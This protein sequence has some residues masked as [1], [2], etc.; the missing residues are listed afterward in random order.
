MNKL[1]SLVAVLAIGLSACNSNNKIS[2]QSPTLRIKAD[3]VGYPAESVKIAIIPDST[4][5]DFEVYNVKTNEVV[6]KGKTSAAQLWSYSQTKVKTADFSE[7]KTQGTYAIRCAGAVD[8]YPFSIGSGIYADLATTAAQS[9]YIQ[10]CSVEIKPEYAGVYARPAA[11]ADN[12][13]IIH[14]SAAGP[15]SKEG[16]VIS[17]SGGWYDAGD[18]GKYII[19]S[20]ITVSTMLNA[21][22]VWPDYAKN[23]KLNIPE[24][25]NQLP[26][27]IDEILV[28]LRW[29]LTMQDKADGGVYH[30]LTALGFCG[31]IMPTDDK[32]ARYVIGKSTASALDFASA[33]AK[34]ARVLKPYKNQLPGFEDSLINQAVAAWNWA[35]KNPK[36]LFEKN[37]DGVVTGMY[38]DSQINDEW[39]WAAMEMFLTT[40]DQKYIAAV[41]ESDFDFNAPVWDS[42]SCLGVYS[43]LADNENSKKLDKSLYNFLKDNFIKEA[44]RFVNNYKSS[45]YKVAL[46]VFPWGS[47]SECANQGCYLLT[48]YKATGKAEYLEAA[49]AALHYILGRN[50]MDICYVTG[51]GTAP[52][53]DPHDRRCVADGVEAPIPGLLTGGPYAKAKGDVPDSLYLY[54]APAMRYVDNHGSYKTNEIAINWN[55]ALQMLVMGV[56]AESK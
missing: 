32:D 27:L 6:F 44:D 16:D 14:K 55:A 12:R 5:E 46:D 37:P 29:M 28:N 33:C 2:Q 13:V 20:A 41:K 54:E 1:F 18:F 26:D 52:A 21:C 4:A 39:T 31:V 8:S 7:F 34:A 47:N 10:R 50:P 49:Q 48:A 43:M 17:C 42:V 3:Q 56:D 53:K 19:N 24:K 30:K 45:S 38:N 11:H 9:F 51:F 40:G 25:N 23:I 35:I 15:V 22:Q 36:V